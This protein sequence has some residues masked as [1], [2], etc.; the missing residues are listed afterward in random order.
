MVLCT[1]CFIDTFC[2]TNR[3]RCADP[4]RNCSRKIK[5]TYEVYSETILHISIFCLC[6][7][8]YQIKLLKYYPKRLIHLQ[9]YDFFS[10]YLYKAV[11][12]YLHEI[13]TYPIVYSCTHFD[14]YNNHLCNQE[15]RSGGNIRSCQLSFLRQILFQVGTSVF[16]VVLQLLMIRS[17]VKAANRKLISF[18][19]FENITFIYRA[20]RF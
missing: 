19:S 6:I 5:K 18:M 10:D 12:L 16:Y 8:H 17:T 13:I 11:V 14:N 2:Q 3:K 7:V 9:R 1:H 20:F 4:S 15:I